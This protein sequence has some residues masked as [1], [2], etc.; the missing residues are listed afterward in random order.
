M[1]ADLVTR[2]A[3]FYGQTAIRPSDSSVPFELN[4]QITA[5]IPQ[6]LLFSVGSFPDYFSK[7]RRTARPVIK[8]EIVK[9]E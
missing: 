2:S 6:S 3:I 1:I 5:D 7:N 8:I 9:S 4:R